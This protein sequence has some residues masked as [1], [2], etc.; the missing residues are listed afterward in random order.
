M[1]YW[2]WFPHDFEIDLRGKVEMRR[3]EHGMTC[4]SIWRMDAPGRSIAFHKRYH[5]DKPGRTQWPAR[6]VPTS[7]WT[8]RRPKIKASGSICLRA[9]I[10]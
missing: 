4:P 10:S 9:I 1:A 5:L 2:I 6:A 7:C 8:A 3:Q